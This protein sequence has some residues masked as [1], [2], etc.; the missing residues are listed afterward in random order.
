M[1]FFSFCFHFLYI[2]KIFCLFLY[3]F[4]AFISLVLS[5]VP[6]L[7]ASPFFFG[8]GCEVGVICLGSSAQMPSSASQASH[9]ARQRILCVR[10]VEKNEIISIFLYF[11]FSYLFVKCITA[12]HTVPLI[13]W[14]NTHREICICI[15]MSLGMGTWVVEKMKKNTRTECNEWVTSVLHIFMIS[16][17]FSVFFCFFWFWILCKK[18]NKMKYINAPAQIFFSINWCLLLCLHTDNDVSD[19]LWVAWHT[20]W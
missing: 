20:Q 6:L 2:I 1:L 11:F 5:T 9:Q 18:K 13:C 15:G 12:K 7:F 8:I 16:Q 14:N 17:T 4:H 19:A 10:K 3:I